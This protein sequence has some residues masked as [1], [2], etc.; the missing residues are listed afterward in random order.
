MFAQNPKAFARIAGGF[1]FIVGIAVLLGW[2]LNVPLLKSVFP[3]LVTMKANT[4]LGMTLSGLT[5]M[6]L[7]RDKIDVPLRFCT[8][9]LAV[10]AVALGALTLG[11]YFLGWNLGIDELLFR[12]AEPIRTSLPGRMS[13]ST[14]FCF[15]LVGSALS[16]ASQ[17]ILSR[18]RFS[19]L[20]GLGATLIILGGVATF[21]QIANVLFH[22]R[23][24]NYFGMAV[25]TAMGFALLGI[26]L[27]SLVKGEKGLA[28][29]L[30]KRITTGFIASIAI[31][32]T[33]AGVSWNYTS[34]LQ[35]AAAWVSHTHQVLKEIGDVRAG[36]AELESSQ[37]GYI[38]L[39]DEHLL[40]SRE[41]IKTEIRKSIE[42]LRS[43]TADNPRQKPRIDQL[44]PLIS[45]RTDFGE[46]TILVRRQQGFASAQHMI[47]LGT[48]MRLSADVEQ[49][50]GALRGEEDS[51]LVTREKKSEMISTATFLLLPTVVFVS[52][53]ILSLA[54]FFLN[55]GVGERM[56]AE[57]AS[58]QLAAIV[59]SS[60][61]AIIGKDLNSVITSWNIGAEEIFGYTANEM[62]GHHTARLI[63]LDRR[64]EEIQINTRVENGESVEHFDTLRLAKDGHLIDISMAVS[65]IKDKA[66]RII[67]ASKVARDVTERKAAEEKIN[68][69]NTKLE[70]R[71]VERTAQLEAA[72]KEL[73]A[74]SYSVSHDLRSP[75][76]AIDGFSQAILE[77][78][79]T[80]LPPEGLHYLQ[81]IREGA[82][83][84]G[85][86]IDDLLTFSHLSRASLNRQTVNT[87]ELVRSVI[88]DLSSERQGRQ[89]EIRIGELL[90][91]QGDRALLKQVWTNLLSNAVKYTRH[92]NPALIEIGCEVE[93]ETIYFV[94][95]NGAGFDMRYVH[96]LFGVF[97]RL[98]ST[99]QF[100]G[101]GVGLAIVQRV[102][103]RH[104]GRVWAEAGLDRGASFYFTL[105]DESKA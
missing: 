38:I 27:L 14:A 70:D 31:M 54:L 90:P 80:Q 65:P 24:W 48:G 72:N 51:L 92:R 87:A 52:L 50:L 47:A 100:E 2:A 37:R 57:E 95:D 102:I 26:G 18:L 5:L 74:F 83:R 85:I 103:N 82:Q 55:S 59:H 1:V 96:K 77:D 29:S 21:G 43:L 94:R 104:G 9:A 45:Q 22:L 7:S 33:A 28:W 73:E 71:V 88:E 105:K 34:E 98:H 35:D 41:E 32:L 15:V 66:G 58:A 42:N 79:G 81:T 17:Q 76:R 6:L 40:A 13:T 10:V 93:Q 89:I 36:M 99:D 63:P 97:Q 53:T 23:L 20:S 56:K 12:D 64:Q 25:H 46:Q 8:V 30:D 91:C 62:I 69:L 3:G 84:M 78:Y 39:G 101:T 68:Q 4:A 67:G 44:A 49:V 16:V 86:L 75:L 11:E 19:I 60:S 61:D